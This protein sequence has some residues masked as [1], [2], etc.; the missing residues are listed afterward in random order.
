MSTSVCVC[1]PHG[2]CPGCHSHGSNNNNNNN[3]QSVCTWYRVLPVGTYCTV[4]VYCNINIVNRD[5]KMHRLHVASGLRWWTR[6]VHSDVKRTALVRS[7]NGPIPT[8]FRPAWWRAAGSVCYC[9]YCG[10]SVLSVPLYTLPVLSVPI[11][12]PARPTW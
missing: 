9:M 1:G 5:G 10:L 6:V 11:A 12:D 7:P 4:G 3:L 8:T 2:S